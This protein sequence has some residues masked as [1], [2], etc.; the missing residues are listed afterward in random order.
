[1]DSVEKSRA[2]KDLSGKQLCAGVLVAG[3]ALYAA[4]SHAATPGK[5]SS[6]INHMLGR[7]TMG[8]TGKSIN[9]VKSIGGIEAYIDEQLDPASIDDATTDQLM[10]G[11]SRLNT[12]ASELIINGQRGKIRNELNGATVVRAV[13]SRRQL[14][15]V[16]VDFWSNHF[17]V[18]TNKGRTAY[19]K[20]AEDALFR[21]RALG[22]FHQLLLASARSP[23]MLSYLDNVTSRADRGAVPNE[24]Y[25]RELLELHTV[26]VNGGYDEQDVLKTA[27]VFSGWSISGQRVFKFKSGRNRLGPL[28][29]SGDIMGWKPVDPSKSERN[30]KS[31]LWYL[32]HHPSTAKFISWKLCRY[33]VSDRIAM[34][35]PLVIQASQTYLENDTDISAVLRTILLST[36]FTE[37]KGEKVKRPNEYL[38]AMLRGTKARLDLS[39]PEQFGRLCRRLLKKQQ[40]VLFEKEPPTGYSNLASSFINTGTLMSR[41]NLAFALTGNSM[42]KTFDIDPAR[43]NLGQPATI[44]QLVDSLTVMLMGKRL[45]IPERDVLYRFLGK[46]A[47]SV[48]TGTDLDQLPALAALVFASASFQVR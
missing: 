40:H 45:H 29:N 38:Y 18:D 21:R 31:L 12:P 46:S 42:G 25:A 10:W 28:E 48:V 22:K 19:Y 26:G 9:Y 36:R 37:S 27:Y 24:N 2:E 23:A 17:N 1:M 14:Q 43:W 7:I 39:D 3:S 33:F 41:W 6:D 5:N 16:M 11:F 34:D 15:E 47:D 13:Q 30:G 8:V 4:A 44:R 35:D 32:S 20:P